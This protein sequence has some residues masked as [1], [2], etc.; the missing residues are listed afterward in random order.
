M[1][2]TMASNWLLFIASRDGERV[3]ASLI[4]I[5]PDRKTAF[6]RYWG[7]TESISCLHFEACY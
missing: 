6:G 4:A 1:R 3:A 7:A 5:D 2:Q